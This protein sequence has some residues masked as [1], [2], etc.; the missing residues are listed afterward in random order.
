MRFRMIRYAIRRRS[1]RGGYRPEVT[2]NREDIDLS[3][4][5]KTYS[6]LISGVTHPAPCTCPSCCFDLYEMTYKARGRVFDRMTFFLDWLETEVRL[7]LIPVSV[8]YD[9]E[10]PGLRL[11]LKGNLRDFFDARGV[12]NLMAKILEEHFPKNKLSAETIKLRL[13]RF[14]KSGVRR[15]LENA[16]MLADPDL[17]NREQKTEENW[18]RLRFTQKIVD[19]VNSQPGKSCTQREVLRHFHKKVDDLSDIYQPEDGIDLFQNRG[20]SVR[21]EGKRRYFS[22]HPPLTKRQLREYKARLNDQVA[23]VVMAW[24]PR[25]DRQKL[26]LYDTD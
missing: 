9:L 4:I 14:K 24:L 22:C 18:E 11:I 26:G 5:K 15:E 7:S 12:F 23:E 13:W 25:K 21:Q 10:K 16:R 2:E 8:D 20:I 17:K 1:T 6:N 3:W 19:Y